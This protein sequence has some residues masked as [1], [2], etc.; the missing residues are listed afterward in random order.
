V[1]KTRVLIPALALLAACHAADSTGPVL[2]PPPSGG[3]TY[4]GFDTSI[5]PG[6]AAMTAW[7]GGSPFQWSGFYLPAPC[8]K[9]ATWS[10]KRTF[11]TGLGWGIA[12]IFVGQ[13][14]F[15]GVA[16]ILTNRLGA[17]DFPDAIAR[18]TVTATCSRTLLSSANGIADADDAIA[19]TLAEGFPAGTVIFLDLEHMDVVTPEMESYYRAWAKRV[20]EAGPYLPG[21]YVHKFNAPTV[22]AGYTE[23]FKAANVSASPRFWLATASGFSLDKKPS[24]IGYAFANMWQGILD[25]DETWSGV[26][27]HIDVDV[28]DRPSPSAPE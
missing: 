11:L 5:Y 1:N 18:A 14:T 16:T 10:G 27:L 8:H 17:V 6:D 13:Q 3:A 20:L 19:K 4:R 7:K 24:D 12:V 28:S 25:T 9:D 21:V 22:Y 15:D 23:V 2:N 26:T